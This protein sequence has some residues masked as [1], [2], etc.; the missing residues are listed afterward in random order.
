MTDQEK[1]TW[2]L[3]KQVFQLK[4]LLEIAQGLSRCRQPDDVY[5]SILATMAGTFGARHALALACSDDQWQPIAVHGNISPAA[6]EQATQLGSEFAQATA[7]RQQEMLSALT[8]SRRSHDLTYSLWEHIHVRDRVVGGLFFGRK[9]LGEPYTRD[10]EQVLHAVCANAASVLE[11]LN[12][13][14]ELQSARQRLTT[15]NLNLRQQVRQELGNRQFIGKS[16]AVRKILDNINNFGRSD[17]TVL[18]IGET[19]TG[20]ELVARAI[21]DASFR[22]NGPFVAINCTAIPENLVESEFFGIE[23][24]T[25]TGVK[26][27]I[28][29]FEQADGGTLFIDEVGDMPLNSQAKLLRSLQE[30]TLRR[31]GGDREIRV[32]VRVLAATNKDLKAEIKNA[33]FR[34]DLY[35]RLSVLELRIPPLRE[36]REDI[37]LLVHHFVDK[38]QKRLGRKIGGIEPETLHVLEKYAW[39]GNVRELENEVERLVTLAD[40]GEI[41]TSEHLSPHFHEESL[42][43]LLA[44]DHPPQSIKEAVDRLETRMIIRALKTAKGNKSEVARQLGLSRLGLQRK[45]ERLRITY[46][47]I[48]DE[49]ENEA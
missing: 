22:S 48:A 26:Q 16:P 37:V 18:I 44:D 36:R 7:R 47:S 39:P 17:A 34:E 40:E 23:A 20:K 30:Q 42:P 6:R 19:G 1:K 28:G 11:N 2:E 21:H 10:D 32:N 15:E 31:V 41:I 5:A 14:Q 3:E 35:Y 24:G 12:L 29:Y 33:R 45:M 13:L 46:E 27:H 8:D 25:A 4:T 49:S 9:I 43:D 38:V